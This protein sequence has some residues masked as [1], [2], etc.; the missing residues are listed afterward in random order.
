MRP[1]LLYFLELYNS[2]EN[3]NPNKQ[4]RS[5]APPLFIWVLR[6]KQNLHCY[7][8]L[9]NIQKQEQDYPNNIDKVPVY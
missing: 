6:P 2:N 5:F 8:F 9:E 4:R 3:Q 1:S 7:I